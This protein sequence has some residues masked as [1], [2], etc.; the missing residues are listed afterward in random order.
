[1][2]EK[3]DFIGANVYPGSGGKSLGLSDNNKNK[4]SLYG[5]IDCLINSVGLNKLWITET[6]LPYKG[7]CTDGNGEIIKF[8]HEIQKSY[9]EDVIELKKKYPNLPIF[10][11]T[12][13]DVPSKGAIP[14]CDPDNNTETH[15]GIISDQKCKRL[16]E[17][18]K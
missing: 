1:M 3:F 4:D 17:N 16:K 2:L 5:Q 6:G 10:L 18:K 15:M 11:F 12:A 13:F 9:T 8:T 14:G 7:T